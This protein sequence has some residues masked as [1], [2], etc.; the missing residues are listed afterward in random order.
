MH[1]GATRLETGWARDEAAPVDS[2]GWRSLTETY[3]QK[4]TGGRRYVESEA[5]E[6]V[7]RRA[8]TRGSRALP[9]QI[10]LNILH[11]WWK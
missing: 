10:S 6:A 4:G 11:P 7:K 3:A 9:L 1:A 8:S 2:E 5:L